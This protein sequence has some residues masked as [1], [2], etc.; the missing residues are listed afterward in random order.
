MKITPRE[1]RLFSLPAACPPFSRGVI[2]TRAR[3]SLALLSLR[4]NVGL[5]VVYNI[6]TRASRFFVHFFAVVARPRH[7]TAG[8]HYGSW[9]CL[10]LHFMEDVNARQRFSYSFLKLRYRPLEFTPKNL[11]TLYKLLNDMEGGVMNFEIGWIQSRHRRR[12]R[13]LSS[14]MITHKKSMITMRLNIHRGYYMAARR[15]EIS[16]RVIYHS[17][18]ISLVRCAHSWNIFQHEKRN[19]VSPSGHVMFYLLYK[20]Q[21]TTKP[22]HFNSFLVWKA[23]FIM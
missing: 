20:H 3:V 17:S 19:F 4:T 13:C 22:F 7:E 18:N 9:N 2:F 6:S 21:W 10:I 16:L 8:S 23:R 1:K 15:Y 12:R 5:L 14:L 11:P